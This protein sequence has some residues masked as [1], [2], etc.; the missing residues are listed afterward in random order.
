MCTCP[1]AFPS[2]IRASTSADSGARMAWPRMLSA[3]RAPLS[4]SVQDWAAKGKVYSWNQFLIPEG[5]RNDT[6]APIYNQFAL[7][8]IDKAK[9]ISLFT[10]AIATLKK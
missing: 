6:L 9:F 5:F 4:A 1:T 7:G 3:F 2:A 8:Q 10:D